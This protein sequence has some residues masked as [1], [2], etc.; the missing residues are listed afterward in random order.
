MKTILFLLMLAVTTATAQDAKQCKGTTA[1]GL[2]CKAIM[3]GKDGYCRSHSP[4]AF[5]CNFVKH[6]NEKC[7]MIVKHEGQRCKFHNDGVNLSR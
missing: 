5:R 1:K 3:I 6:N 4:S 7:K 2:P